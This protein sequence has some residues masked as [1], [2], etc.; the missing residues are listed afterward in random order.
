M[1]IRNKQDDAEAFPY[2]RTMKTPPQDWH[3]KL[4]SNFALQSSFILPP[5]GVSSDKMLQRN[6]FRRIGVKFSK[7]RTRL[8]F[9]R[10][11]ESKFQYNVSN[12]YI[13]NFFFLM[14]TNF[15]NNLA[16]R[17]IRVERL[18]S[19]FQNNVSD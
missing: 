17:L 12:S 8:T 19:N 16:I 15:Q 5:N 14:E 1:Q 4:Q 18:Q 3:A 13:L 2:L 6:D 11:L 10:R 7:Y 9:V